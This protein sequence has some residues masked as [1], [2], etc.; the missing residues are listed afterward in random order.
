MKRISVI[1]CPGA[2]KSTLSRELAQ[3]TGLPVIHLDRLYWKAGWTEENPD[4]FKEKLNTA[5]HRP[6]WIIDG[7]YHNHMEER[8]PQTDTLIWLDYATWRCIWRVLK[9][10]F[11][12][13]GKTRPDAAEGCP[14]RFNTGFLLYVLQFRKKSRPKMQKAIES[15]GQNCNMIIFKNPAELKQWLQ[16]YRNHK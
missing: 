10:T 5:L 12:S 7:N 14:E 2:G 3:I 8:L 11:A 13:Y 15:C 16:N 4:M 9:R 6:E 1:G